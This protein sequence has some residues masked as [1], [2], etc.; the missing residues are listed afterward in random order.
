[1]RTD[2]NATAIAALE[3]AILDVEMLCNSLRACD[4]HH[5]NQDTSDLVSTFERHTAR[6][7]AAFE[8]AMQAGKEGSQ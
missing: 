6:L 5:K 1:M 4:P 7:R 8:A 2:T 3:E